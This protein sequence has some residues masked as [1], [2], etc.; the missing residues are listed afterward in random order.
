MN[1]DKVIDSPALSA[2]SPSTPFAGSLE[3]HRLDALGK[4]LF[5]IDIAW[6]CPM[7]Y[8]C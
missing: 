2:S 3:D 5:L 4:L 1:R 7:R 6:T 8:L